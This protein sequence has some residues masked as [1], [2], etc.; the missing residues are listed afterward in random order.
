MHLDY[1]LRAEILEYMQKRWFALN[2]TG[3]H[4]VVIALIREGQLELACDKL[5]KMRRDGMEIQ[6]WLDDAAVYALTDAGEMEEALQ[7][8]K[9]RASRGLVRISK[10]VWY[11]LLDTASESR[12]VSLLFSVKGT[13]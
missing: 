13:I 12:H 4:D 11:R 8:M 3:H 6:N 9:Q 1:L 5:S 10:S 2:E 7:I